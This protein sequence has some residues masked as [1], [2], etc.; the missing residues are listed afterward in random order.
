MNQRQKRYFAYEVT[1]TQKCDMACTYCFEGEELQNKNPQLHTDDIIKSVHEMLNGEKFLE[2]FN[3]VTINFW[4]GEPTLNSKMII[5]LINEFKDSPVDFFMYTNGFNVKNIEKIINNF[6]LFIDD[7]SRFSYQISY[8]GLNNDLERVDHKGEGTSSTVL[9]S[10]HYL[11]DK[12][13]D[14]KLSIKSTLAIHEMPNLLENWLHFKE[15]IEKYPTFNYSPTLEYTNKYVIDEP[16]LKIV[17][18]QFL[19]IAKLE[20]EYYKANGRF[21]WSW[22]GTGERNVCSAGTNI[23]NV[24]IDGNLL[25]C[26]GA[27]YSENK[28]DFIIG[29]IDN[30]VEAVMTSHERHKEIMLVPEH[31]KGCTATVCYQCPIVNHDTSTKETYEE[32]YHDPKDDLCGIYKA[33]GKIDRTVQKHLGI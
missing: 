2:V 33:F 16:F 17:N 19:K 31:C 10:V 14:I 5:R 26:H 20:I 6:K 32:K 4:G 9:S 12:F 15:L 24:D 13:P 21:V 3:G 29:H 1:T 27:L 30:P 28:E 23:A 11:M 8:D 18:E 7:T 25:V 22:F